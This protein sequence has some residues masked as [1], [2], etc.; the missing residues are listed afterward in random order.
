MCTLRSMFTFKVWKRVYVCG[1]P[2]I[3]TWEVFQ[4]HIFMWSNDLI[5]TLMCKATCDNMK[6]HMWNVPKTDFRENVMWKCDFLHKIML[7]FC[8]GCDWGGCLVCVTESVCLCCVGVCARL[9]LAWGLQMCLPACA[10]GSCVSSSCA[11]TAAWPLWGIY[12]F[13]VDHHFQYFLLERVDVNPLFA[14]IWMNAPPG[15]ICARV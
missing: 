11:H 1:V 2:Y 3:N 6:L 12:M 4:K 10:R 15:E 7:L 14:A 8:K 5:V 13:D 9:A